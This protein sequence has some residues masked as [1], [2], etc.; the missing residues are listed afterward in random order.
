MR[1]AVAALAGIVLLGVGLLAGG[2]SLVF[3]PALFATGEFS[4]SD[5]LPIWL[6]GLSL[7]AAGLYAAVRLLRFANRT[8]PPKE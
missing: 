2:C 3:T 7:G 6:A 5:M 1:R 8:P 4:G